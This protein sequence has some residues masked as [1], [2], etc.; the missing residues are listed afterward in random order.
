MPGSIHEAQATSN[1]L[2]D[3]RANLELARKE[4]VSLLSKVEVK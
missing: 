3:A 1:P 2:S 4:A